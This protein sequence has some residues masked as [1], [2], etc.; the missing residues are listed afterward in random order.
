MGE[1]STTFGGIHVSPNAVATIAYQATLESYGV[2]GLAARN[3]AD[4]LVKTITRDPSRGITVKYNGEEIDI[5]IHIIVEYGTRIS[6]V[7]E[8]VANTVRFHVE[9][10]LG[11]KVNF[12]NVHVAGLRVSNTD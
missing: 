9:K 8:S 11:L 1:D 2:V 4:G 6:S 10:A 3:L 5:E 12:V 7:A